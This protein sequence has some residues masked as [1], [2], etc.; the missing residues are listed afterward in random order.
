MTFLTKATPTGR[1]SISSLAVHVVSKYLPD[2]YESPGITSYVYSKLDSVMVA[3]PRAALPADCKGT[4]LSVGQACGNWWV[5]CCTVAAGSDQ[6]CVKA[7]GSGRSVL[8]TTFA[9]MARREFAKHRAAAG[10][11]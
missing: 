8:V 1:Y 11:N 4:P 5:D 7:F 2:L 6:T 9:A 10:E 3:N